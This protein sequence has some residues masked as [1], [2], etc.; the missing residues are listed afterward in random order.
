M[1]YNIDR[2]LTSQQWFQ[3]LEPND[4]LLL[5][6]IQHEIEYEGIW[7]IN[8]TMASYKLKI[9]VDIERF[10]KTVNRDRE[11]FMF[12]DDGRRLFYIPWLWQNIAMVDG[13]LPLKCTTNT[14][15][16]IVKRLRMHEETSNWLTNMERSG[17]L[18]IFNDPKGLLENEISSKIKKEHNYKCSYCQS[19]FNDASLQIDHVHPVSRGGTNNTYNLTPACKKCNME[20][21]NRD[22]LQYLASKG[23]IPEGKLV[24][25]LKYLIHH[26]YIVGDL[27]KDF[28]SNFGTL[29]KSG[30]ESAQTLNRVI[31]ESEQ[32]LNRV[33]E[34]S[35]KPL[36]GVKLDS[37]VQ[38]QKQYQSQSQ[39]ISTKD[40]AI[41][42]N[43]P[44]TPTDQPDDLKEWLKLYGK[45]T[46]H[47]DLVNYWQGLTP[48]EKQRVMNATRKLKKEPRFRTS[49]YYFLSRKEYEVPPEKD[50]V[51]SPPRSN[52]D[53]HGPVPDYGA[54][55]ERLAREAE[56]KRIEREAKQNQKEN[57]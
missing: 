28:T 47:V 13:V 10:V 39:I 41:K 40:T 14:N 21:S 48:D 24:E 50:A 25:S 4:K 5:M 54:A 19:V 51:Y 52:L 36:N 2:T 35:E 12:C 1:A 34:E 17:K 8:E 42:K 27:A 49:P 43:T 56:Q 37:Q 23:I 18:V 32:I 6:F 11:R 44:R 46:G 33:R 38:L 31:P 3:D 45:E 26:N 22:P 57:A 55:K 9:E 7:L 16:T 30:R 20:K 15:L 53:R 29:T